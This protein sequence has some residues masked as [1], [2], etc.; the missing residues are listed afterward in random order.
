M[1][2]S[3]YP[4][5]LPYVLVCREGI[6]DRMTEDLF[7]KFSQITYTVNT[8]YRCPS[9]L[10]VATFMY[11]ILQWGGVSYTVNKLYTRV[12]Y[13]HST[14][15]C[16]LLYILCQLYNLPGLAIFTMLPTYGMLK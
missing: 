2:E 10:V 16:I 5:R 6:E 4:S 15:I 13:T 12:W 1:L 3:G 8:V 9:L 11:M 7:T 14:Q